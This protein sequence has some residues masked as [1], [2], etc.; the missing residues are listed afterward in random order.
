MSVN[1]RAPLE[2]IRL[3]LP[4]MREKRTG[5]ILNVSSVGGMMAMPTMGI[6][7]ASKF[8]L[9]GA[10]EALW[11]EMRPWNIHVSLIQPGFIH[12]ESFAK[13]R[14][15]Q[16]SQWSWDHNEEAYHAHYEHMTGMIARLMN[17]TWATPEHVANVVVRTL[18][19]RSPPL[20]V[21]ATPDARIF[22][23]IRRFMPRKLYHR[24][25]YACLPKVKTWGRV[26]DSRF[27]KEDSKVS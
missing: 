12:S 16:P 6:Y 10:S 11:Y 17:G 26:K 4:R 5:R 14:Y 23:L 18:G 25:L 15:S 24:I 22:G 1:F 13:T 2:M 8:A 21:A 9:E 7:S 19:R 3:V 20:R 27:E